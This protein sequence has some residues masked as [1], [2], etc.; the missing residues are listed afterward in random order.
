MVIA[1][2]GIAACAFI[3]YGTPRAAD[4]DRS[5]GWFAFE[6]APWLIL[7]LLAL[8]STYSRAL[9]LGAVLMLALEIYA[10]WIVFMLPDGA[11]AAMIYLWKPLLGVAIAGLA[12]LGALIMARAADRRG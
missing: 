12:M 2:S 3:E 9:A 6:A 11:N 8:F 5:A 7:L 10:W 1:I 4:V